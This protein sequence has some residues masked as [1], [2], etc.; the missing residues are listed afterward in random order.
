MPKLESRYRYMPPVGNEYRPDQRVVIVQ[1]RGPRLPT[2]LPF[3][4][5]WYSV[6]I[7]GSAAPTV[8]IFPHSLVD[9]LVARG[10]VDEMNRDKEVQDGRAWIESQDGLV[11]AQ[12]RWVKRIVGATLE[13]WQT[14]A[15]RRAQI[16]KEERCPGGLCE[17]GECRASSSPPSP[18]LRR[19]THAFAPRCSHTRITPLLRATE[20][21]RRRGRLPLWRVIRR[22]LQRAPRPLASREAHGHGPAG[23]AAELLER[24]PRVRPEARDLRRLRRGAAGNPRAQIIFK[25]RQVSTA[26][27]KQATTS[28]SGVE[29]LLDNVAKVWPEMSREAMLIDPWKREGDYAVEPFSQRRTS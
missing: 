29:D 8:A 9:A 24:H 7:D 21:P 6:A 1:V 5:A 27:I 4:T 22:P 14:L 13:E 2:G 28:S 23:E 17:E 11:V 26:A 10:E 25:G 18:P 12:R 20:A 19:S 15:A 3:S 16:E